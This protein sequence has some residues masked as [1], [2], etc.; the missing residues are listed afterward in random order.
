M[1][2]LRQ[3]SYTRTNGGEAGKVYPRFF[4]DSVQD[5]VA[6]EREGRPIFKDEERVE[7]IFPGNQH[8]KPVWKVTQEHKERWPQ[9]YEAFK[10]GHEIALNG[11]PLEQWPIL[12]RAQVM[13]LKAMNF[14]TVEDVAGMNDHATQRI[15]MGGVRLR[16]LAQ[17]YLDE[18]AAGALLSQTTAA[19]ARQE[20]VIAEQNAKIDNLSKLCERLSAELIQMR[21]APS[22]IATYVPGQHDPAEAARQ[23][24]PREEAAGSSLLDLPQPRKRAKATDQAA[25]S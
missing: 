18:A 25:A 1:S 9:E 22:P 8:T 20:E 2:E 21:N 12:K 16:Q 23:A 6:S 10:S 4:I 5:Y 3:G 14:R 24:A 19:N 15:G 7:V 17:S 11:T 13:E